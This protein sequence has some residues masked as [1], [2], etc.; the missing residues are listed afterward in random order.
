MIV[1]A[2]PEPRAQPIRD[3]KRVIPLI[4]ADDEALADLELCREIDRKDKHE[5]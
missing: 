1:P 5:G 3:L 4:E 2:R